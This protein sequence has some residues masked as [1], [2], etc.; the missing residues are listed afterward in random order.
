MGDEFRARLILDLAHLRDEPAFATGSMMHVRTPPRAEDPFGHGFV[1][2]IDTR[3]ETKRRL[4]S[5]EP[6]LRLLLYLW[7]V[8]ERPVTEIAARLGC[9]RVHCYRLRDRGLEALA[10][11]MTSDAATREQAG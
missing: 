7:Y 1:A 3:A 8:E 6:R 4:A 9:S 10:K 5:L 2:H 11:S